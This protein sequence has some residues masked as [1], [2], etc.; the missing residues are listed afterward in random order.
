H[1]VH[2][3]QIRIAGTDRLDIEIVQRDDPRQAGDAADEGGDIMVV[4]LHHDVDRQLDVELLG[5]FRLQRDGLELQSAV[6]AHLGNILK[7]TGNLGVARQLLQQGA[8]TLFDLYQLCLVGLQVGRLERLLGKFLAQGH[9]LAFGPLQA[10]LQ[11]L[12]MEVV[13]EEQQ[14]REYHHGDDDLQCSRPGP[15]IVEVKVVDIDLLQTLHGLS[16]TH[17]C[18]SPS[19]ASAP[20]SV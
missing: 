20:G 1:D 12:E 3:Q 18:C 15:D 17:C 19:A 13:T 14:H 11:I 2:L 8:E 10:G 5:H 6:E 9:F 16:K 4:A 7:Q